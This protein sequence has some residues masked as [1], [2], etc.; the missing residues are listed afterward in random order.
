MSGGENALAKHPFPQT[1]EWTVYSTLPPGKYLYFGYGWVGAP[2]QV[3]FMTAIATASRNPVL[4]GF[5]KR[6]LKASSNPFLLLWFDPDLRA[7]NLEGK[8]PRG[9][10]FYDNGAQL[11]SRSDWDPVRAEMI[12]YVKAKRDHNHAHNDVGQL[13]IDARGQRMIVDPGSPSGYSEDFFDE[14]RWKYYNA[15]V[16]GHNVP[17]FGGREQLSPNSTRGVKTG[18]DFASVSGRI[19]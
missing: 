18:I 2:P 15:S 12:V 3:E 11:F 4:Q 14:N 6:F 19:L 7:E 13:C 17:M 8:L 5:C 9:R 16:L 10:A 1:G